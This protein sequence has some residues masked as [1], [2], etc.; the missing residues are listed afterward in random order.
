MT[1]LGF[2]LWCGNGKK[3]V[4]NMVCEC[5]EY[6]ITSSLAWQLAL[7]ATPWHTLIFICF[8]RFWPST[9]LC[10]PSTPWH[11]SSFIG[12]LYLALF[13]MH[14]HFI[15]CITLL[16]THFHL[17]HVS[18]WKLLGCL[19]CIE[20]TWYG[21]AWLNIKVIWDQLLDSRWEAIDEDLACRMH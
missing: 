2:F 14:C 17:A 11:S 8:H 12:T 5:L 10:C 19:T 13:D 3:W 1:F 18:G 20:M 15:A 9:P 16:D 6:L 21:L 7:I 4:V